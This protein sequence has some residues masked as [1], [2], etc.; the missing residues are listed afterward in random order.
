MSTDSDVVVCGFLDL[1]NRLSETFQFVSCHEE[2]FKTYSVR[3]CGLLLEAGSFFD[4]LAQT[5]IRSRHSSGQPFIS[6]AKIPDLAKKLAGK[7]NF[8]AADYRT[9]FEEEPSLRFSTRRVALNVYDNRFFPDLNASAAAAANG[10]APYYICPFCAWGSGESPAW[11]KAFTKL[12]HDRTQFLGEASLENLLNACGA[13][14]I[15]LVFAHEKFARSF[16]SGDLFRVFSPE[17]LRPLA[18][19]AM[20]SRSLGFT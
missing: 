10:T 17:F 19:R 11:W 13:V 7:A 1:Q 15:M 6:D 9:L 8:T 20:L 14:L 3:F 2:N 16:A 5:Y 12:K 4:S 18:S